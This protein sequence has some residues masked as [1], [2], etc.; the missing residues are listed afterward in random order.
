[1]R[2]SYAAHGDMWIALETGAAR[3]TVRRAR[4]QLGIASAPVGRRRGGV[5][6]IVLTHADADGHERAVIDAMRKLDTDGRAAL[7]SVAQ[8]FASEAD[9]GS[10]RARATLPVPGWTTLATRLVA[11]DG[12][13]RDRDQALIDFE[14]DGCASAILLLRRQQ[15]LAA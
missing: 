9:L 8:R 14:L 6:T 15:S 2:R 3:G 5:N 4:R 10:R 1:M 12:A 11:L 7:A 13:R